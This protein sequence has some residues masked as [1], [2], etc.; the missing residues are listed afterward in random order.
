MRMEFFGL[1]GTGK[2]TIVNELQM[3]NVVLRV[4]VPYFGKQRH[5]LYL[6]LKHI[7]KM[8]YVLYGLFFDPIF[9]YNC[10]KKLC[11]SK[12]TY[13]IDF[14]KLNYQ[15]LALIGFHKRH[16]R[17]ITLYDQGFIQWVWSVCYLSNRQ[18]DSDFIDDLLDC[19]P[20]P[21]MVFYVSSDSDDIY[22]RLK[23]RTLE[24]KRF[25]FTLDVDRINKN[26][27]IC[28]KIILQL[29][30]RGIQVHSLDNPNGQDSLKAL[31]LKVKEKIDC[32]LPR[33]KVCFIANSSWYLWN[34]RKN[35]I[36]RFVEDGYEV[37]AIA[38]DRK[39]T[40][41]IEK[42]G[43]NTECFQLSPT[44]VNPLKEI[45][46][47]MSMF[48]V[49]QTNDLDAIFSFNPKVNFYT[50]IVVFFKK[51]ILFLP[52]ISGMGQLKHK[53]GLLGSVTKHL[54]A[55]LCF[56]ANRIFVQNDD[57]H[58]LLSNNMKSNEVTKLVLLPG[59]GVSLHEFDL[60]L[61]NPN[62]SLT[63]GMFSRIM[64]AKGVKHFLE[65]A[66]HFSENPNIK[67]LLGGEI[68][69]QRLDQTTFTFM[70]R[71]IE[72]GV[73]S[74]IGNVSAIKSY[75][76]E[77]TVVVLPTYYSEGTPR[78]LIEALSIGRI[79]ITTDRPGC[80]DTILEGRNGYLVPCHDSTNIISSISA[81][82]GKSLDER[83]EMCLV[84]RSIAETKFDERIVINAYLDSLSDCF[85]N[86][87]LF[88][89]T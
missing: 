53:N 6:A 75:L 38:P 14:L 86:D 31:T 63:I 3:T 28:D 60:H 39:F 16:R 30:R 32:S 89:T 70:Q 59:S 49:L 21:N 58:A 71:L 79:V 24:R 23:K 34:F 41:E 18:I 87:L 19:L 42:L 5:S 40:S 20:L 57:D 26:S 48:N 69:N 37:L 8:F 54:T 15:I 72:Q 44:S 10:I 76:I 11:F 77:S 9:S 82:S 64:D 65:A 36:K 46:A 62:F 22:L 25:S 84:S 55:L 61:L 81:I 43:A 2:S 12:Q 51:K 47:L 4:N 7:N 33:M 27:L 29:T 85:L 83:Q 17:K 88:T 52:N 66:D 45:R 1:S 80:R 56:R 35:T 13:F 73:I 68:I 74:Y 50:C 78:I 67:F